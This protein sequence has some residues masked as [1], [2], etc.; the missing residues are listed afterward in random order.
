MWQL[1]GYEM[2]VGPERHSL[3]CALRHTAGT[4]KRARIEP[5]IDFLDTPFELPPI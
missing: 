1:F 4:R 2:G 3:A 5:S